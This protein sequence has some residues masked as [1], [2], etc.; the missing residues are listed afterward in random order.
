MKTGKGDLKGVKFEYQM[1][2]KAIK[3]ITKKKTAH[4]YRIFQEALTNIAKAFIAK[5]NSNK[6]KVFR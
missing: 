5:K 1:D 2:E 4:L 3:K 6:H